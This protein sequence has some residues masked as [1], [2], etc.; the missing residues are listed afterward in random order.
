MNHKIILC[1]LSLVIVI[2]TIALI[3]YSHVKSQ[4]VYTLKVFE[5]ENGWGYQIYYKE[6]LVIKQNHIPGIVNKKSFKTKSDANK[7]G[8]LVISRLMQEQ[9]PNISKED[10]DE[11]EVSYE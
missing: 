1:I 4:E 10:L 3:E 7:I 6:Q 5:N 8:H 11:S 9:P 2:S